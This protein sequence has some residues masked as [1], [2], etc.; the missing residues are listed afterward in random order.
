MQAE[1]LRQ[2]RMALDSGGGGRRVGRACHC[3]AHT[4]P[5]ASR[6]RSGQ[7]RPGPASRSRVESCRCDPSFLTAVLFRMPCGLDSFFL[8]L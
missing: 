3:D 5:L 4:K 1:D 2:V 7:K 6:V 8:T